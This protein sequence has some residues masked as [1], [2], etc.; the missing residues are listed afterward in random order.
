MG[1]SEG[2]SSLTTESHSIVMV[3]RETLLCAII[4]DIESDLS[5]ARM[6]A[7]SVVSHLEDNFPNQLQKYQLNGKYLFPENFLV[8]YLQQEFNENVEIST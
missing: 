2:L 5:V 3:K 7:E 6:V 1:G 4:T 8:D